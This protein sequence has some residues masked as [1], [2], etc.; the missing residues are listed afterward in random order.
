[1]MGGDLT[2]AW[3]ALS[4]L[5]VTGFTIGIILA[6]VAGAIRIGWQLAPYVFVGALLLW[7][8]GG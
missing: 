4:V 3:D 8:F 6:V 2:M 7:F 5:I 1:M